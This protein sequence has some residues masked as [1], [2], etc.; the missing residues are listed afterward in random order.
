MYSREASGNI[1]SIYER[2]QDSVK[3]SEWDMYGSSRIGTL[4]TALLVYPRTPLLPIAF[5]F[6][7]YD[8]SRTIYTEGQKQ[9]ELTNHLGNVFVTL[10]DKKIPVDTISASPAIANYYLPLVI[11][12]QDYYP[13]GMLQPGRLFNSEKYKFGYNKGS[14]KDDEI[15]GTGNAY[16]TK[17]R[18]LDVQLDRWLSR[19]PNT[20]AFES[21]YVSTGDNPIMYND[22]NGDT[23]AFAKGV[24]FE[25]IVQFYQAYVYLASHNAA[26]VLNK[27]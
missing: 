11:T 26:D 10:S 25:F 7:P 4:D 23:L 8:T 18:E 20:N 16:T 24:S 6:N 2:K 27:L 3:V 21:P 19:D 22:A 5:I 15:Y 12:S 14:E 1:L 13:F 9:Y 17:F